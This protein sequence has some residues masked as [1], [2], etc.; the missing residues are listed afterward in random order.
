MR[1]CRR[2]LTALLEALEQPQR[3]P[4]QPQLQPQLL[5]PAAPQLLQTF[6]IE[7]ARIGVAYPFHALKQN[8]RGPVDSELEAHPKLT[9]DEN[10]R[11]ESKSK[12][13]LFKIVKPLDPKKKLKF[14]VKMQCCDKKGALLFQCDGLRTAR[15][16]SG[17]R[18]RD[19]ESKSKQQLFHL[20]KPLD[21]NNTIKFTIKTQCHVKKGPFRIHRPQHQPLQLQPSL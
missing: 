12:G 10:E 7:H 11:S 16:S 4:Q 2:A 17:G 5:E 9:I 19:I 1:L 15:E 13:R 3:H 8:H 18:R 6:V 14:T 21:D 20:E